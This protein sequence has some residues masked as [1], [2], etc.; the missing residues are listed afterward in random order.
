[1]A[2]KAFLMRDRIHASCIESMESQPLDHQGKS[3]L[4]V[5]VNWVAGQAWKVPAALLTPL[6][7]AHEFRRKL[8][9]KVE[10]WFAQ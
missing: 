2:C 7:T 5:F 6:Q 4:N 1:M 9:Y 8:I 3:I 10:K